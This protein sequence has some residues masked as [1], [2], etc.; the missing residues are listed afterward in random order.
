[1]GVYFKYFALIVLMLFGCY[2]GYCFQENK[3]E[4][5]IEKTD[6]FINRKEYDSAIHYLQ[7]QFDQENKKVKI[8]TEYYLGNIEL[9]KRKFK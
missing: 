7:Q 2:Y 5:V 1:M 9:K 4:S 3:I 6:D 8:V